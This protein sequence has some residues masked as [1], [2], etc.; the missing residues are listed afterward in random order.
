MHF[1]LHSELS[2]G[3]ESLELNQWDFLTLKPWL[4]QKASG[5][6]EILKPK[7][8][9]DQPQNELATIKKWCIAKE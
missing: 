2:W 3:K 8:K 7:V 4:C 5:L 1:P 9:L 6:D